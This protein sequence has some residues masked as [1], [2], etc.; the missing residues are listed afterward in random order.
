MKVY[1]RNIYLTALLIVNCF[2][3]FS[4]SKIPG[5]SIIKYFHQGA[6]DLDNKA[7][8]C[9]SISTIKA[10]IAFFGVS[11]VFKKVDTLT[12]KYVITLRNNKVLELTKKEETLVNKYD[13]F[14]YTNKRIHKVAEFMYAVMAKNYLIRLNYE[15]GEIK[16]VLDHRRGLL[17]LS[18]DTEEN[19][20]LLGLENN[21]TELDSLDG[22]DKMT[23]IVIASDYH[24]VYSNLGFYDEFGT[25]HIISDFENVFKH[26]V[27]KYAYAL[28]N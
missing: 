22:I 24:S 16:D 17:W 13:H 7:R 20:K 12:N 18:Q 28:K 8:N 11:S 4:Q 2:C 1:M 25:K 3:A 26:G 6:F 9:A 19:F 14:G 10:S 23:N 5:D 21:Y 15:G 27:I